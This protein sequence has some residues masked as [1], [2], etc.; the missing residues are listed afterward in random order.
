MEA[1]RAIT[2][3]DIYKCITSK[4]LVQLDWK[5][6]KIGNVVDKF[7]KEA[8][9]NAGEKSIVDNLQNDPKI[10]D[11]AVNLVSGFSHQTRALNAIIWGLF[12]LA[13]STIFP[14]AAGMALKLL[15]T[16]LTG[17]GLAVLYDRKTT[18]FDLKCILAVNYNH[19]VNDWKTA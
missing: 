18:V 11:K 10:L 16:G 17:V 6:P 12:S 15:G 5:S 8:Q 2:N 13:I 19:Y 4:P 7:L 14:P 3:S 1:V 9:D